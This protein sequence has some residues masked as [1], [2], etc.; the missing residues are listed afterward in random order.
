MRGNSKL[1][2]LTEAGPELW[3]NVVQIPFSLL[4]TDFFIYWIHRGLH[5]RLVYKTLHKP[6]HRW[7]MP[8]PYASHAFHRLDGF[9][10][11]VP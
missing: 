2:D 11:S 4:F 9:A 7:I 3:Y 6:H 10:Q 1:Y 5:H 8:T